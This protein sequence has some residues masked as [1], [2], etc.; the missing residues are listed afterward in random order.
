MPTKKNAP[1]TASKTPAAKTPA[2]KAPSFEDM[3]SAGLG[4]DDVVDAAPVAPEDVTTPASAMTVYQDAPMMDSSDLFI[5]RLRLAQGLTQEVQQGE[6]KPG[7][8]LVLGN[9]PMGS[10]VVVPL[11]MARR[12]ELRETDGGRTVLCRSTDSIVGVGEPG[13]ECETCPMSH[14]TQDP[15]NPKKNRAPKC[16]FIYS[17]LVYIV[18]TKSLAILEFYRTSV[19]AGKMVNTFI[20]QRGLGHFAIQLSAASSQ[21]PRGTYYSPV[22]RY[23]EATPELLAEAHTN[24]PK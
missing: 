1:K 21:G 20:V 10:A 12:R 22:V 7:Q 14:W 18:E 16:T 13:G 19:S 3:V 9:P 8:W 15:S 23:T 5:P 17:Y 11:K 24:A 6:A 4:E 2:K